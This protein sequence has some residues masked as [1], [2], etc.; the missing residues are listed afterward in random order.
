MEGVTIHSMIYPLHEGGEQRAIREELFSAAESRRLG[1]LS[2]LAIQLALVQNTIR[3]ELRNPQLVVL[4][5]SHGFVQSR[6][7]EVVEHSMHCVENYATG[8]H[9]VNALCRRYGF[10]MR[11]V[12]AGLSMPLAARFGVTSF[13]ER[14]GTRDFFEEGAMLPDEFQR[15]ALRGRQLANEAIEMG[16]N[17]LALG[18]I[19]SGGRVSA[20]LV[21]ES[22]LGLG[23]DV[24]LPE[25]MHFTTRSLVSRE[26]CWRLLDRAPRRGD[27]REAVIRYGGFEMVMAMGLMLQAAERRVLVLIDSFV[28]LVALLMAMQIEPYVRDYAVLAHMESAAGME[29]LA[30]R[31]G[32]CPVVRLGLQ[33]TEGVGCLATY[34]LLEASVLLLTLPSGEIGR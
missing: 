28:M 11:I 26:E 1:Q 32:L 30:R 9:F 2:E 21:A 14:R 16:C 29:V 3:P 17:V 8:K 12:D 22:M 33:T 34:P 13:A 23:L 7:L 4:A 19:A 20:A 24:L 6:S 25:D 18:C 10:A 15:V 31:M 5:S 27:W